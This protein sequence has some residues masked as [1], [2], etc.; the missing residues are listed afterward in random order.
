MEFGLEAWT[1]LA[2]T[3]ESKADW[4]HWLAHDQ[5]ITEQN[6][7]PNLKHIPMMLRRRFDTIGKCAMGAV[8]QLCVDEE[9]IGSIFASQHGDIEV[10]LSL[11]EGIA[12]KEE[13]SPTAF[14]LAVHNAIA[15]LYSI[16]TKNT[17]NIT[18]I[19]AMQGHIASALFESIGQLQTKERVLCVIYDATLP[20]V[21]AKT[22]C[23]NPFPYAIALIF[24]RNEGTTMSFEYSGESSQEESSA[25]ENT[26][27]KDL[28]GFIAFLLGD[29]Q[30]FSCESNGSSWSLQVAQGQ[31]MPKENHA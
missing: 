26:A 30:H 29:N 23:S 6:V 7:K 31:N 17:G 21:Y 12:K 28:Q 16:V 15:G 18:A 8:S 22:C 13:M 14:S 27:K 9:N 1:A 5:E 25:F 24:S 2:P 3:L 11:L 19:S 4:Q 20:E 10:T